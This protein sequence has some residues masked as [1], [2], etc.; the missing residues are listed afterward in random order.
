MT[1]GSSLVEDG[2][3]AMVGGSGEATQCCFYP[4]SSS[5]TDGCAKFRT[6][7]VTWMSLALSQ[8]FCKTGTLF[9]FLCVAGQGTLT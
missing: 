7:Q 9:V 6:V 3:R 4:E 1:D 2:M 8:E 5:R